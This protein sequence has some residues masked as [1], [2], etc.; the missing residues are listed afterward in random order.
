MEHLVICGG[1]HN[2]NS[3]KNNGVGFLEFFFIFRKKVSWKF[4]AFVRVYY[5]Y[6]F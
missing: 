2:S 5:V 3:I 6:Y 4:E 1:A